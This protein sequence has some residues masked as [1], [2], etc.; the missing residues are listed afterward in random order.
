MWHMP[1]RFD[2][3]NFSPGINVPGDSRSIR[4]SHARL[5]TLCR[6][7]HITCGAAATVSLSILPGLFEVFEY[8]QLFIGILFSLQP[9]IHS[10]QLIMNSGIVDANNRSLFEYR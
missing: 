1:Q 4:A 7:R 9:G 5:R 10:E 3:I 8:R 6:L 2:E